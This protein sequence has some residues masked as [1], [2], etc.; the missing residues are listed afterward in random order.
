MRIIN[1]I[2]GILLGSL[3]YFIVEKNI[4]CYND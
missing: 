2:V 3:S 4:Y 1:S